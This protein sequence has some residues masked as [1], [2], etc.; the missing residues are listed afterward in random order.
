MKQ[1]VS[2]L[3]SIPLNEERVVLATGRFVGEGFDD[4]RLDTLFLTLPISWKGTIAQYVGRLHRL[5][6]TKKEVHVYD[7]ADFAVP[8]LERMFQR[9]SSA[10]ESVGY[11]IIQPASAYPGWP[12]DVVLPVEPLWKNDYGSTIRRLVS[13]GIDNSLAQ[14][15]SDVAM[16]ESDQIDRARSLIEAFLF[17]RLETLPETKGQFQ[18]NHVLT[19]PFDGLGGMEV[20]LICL[21]AWVAIEIDGIQHLSSKEAYR[22]DRRKDL[23]LQE[24][25]YMVLRFLAEDVSKRLDVV[26]DTILRVLHRNHKP[27]LLSVL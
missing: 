1:A 27:M 2:K 3:T 5:H 13:D 12:S 7:Y 17:C 8:M 23:L 9:R 26:L 14:L 25:G 20:D 16:L 22:T 21:D 10:Y 6:D 4:A 11:K 24:N 19:I 18:L 15:F